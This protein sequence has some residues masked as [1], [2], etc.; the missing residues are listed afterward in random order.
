MDCLTVLILTLASVK[1]GLVSLPDFPHHPHQD[2]FSSTDPASSFIAAGRK[3]R[4]YFCFQTFM[5]GL[6]VLTPLGPVLLLCTGKVQGLL[7]RLLL[8]GH[9]RVPRTNFPA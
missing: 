3:E 1:V 4:E 5:A 2:K 9:S 7:S 6:C 8:L